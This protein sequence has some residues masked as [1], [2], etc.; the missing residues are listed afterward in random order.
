MAGSKKERGLKF[1]LEKPSRGRSLH[2]PLKA[3]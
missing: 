3:S 1:L 2:G